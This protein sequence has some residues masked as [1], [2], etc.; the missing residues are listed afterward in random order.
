MSKFFFALVI[1][2]IVFIHCCDADDKKKGRR[3]AN[4]HTSNPQ[5]TRDNPV[6]EQGKSRAE[7]IRRDDYYT[8][9]E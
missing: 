2:T 8:R 3:T 5:H 7:Q 9:G 1:V 6:E 4:K